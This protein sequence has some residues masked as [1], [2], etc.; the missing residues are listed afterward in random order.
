[1]VG[2]GTRV[3]DCNHKVKELLREWTPLADALETF[4]GCEIERAHTA[5]GDCRA[6][7]QLLQALVT[8]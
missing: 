7:L 6:A 4:A 1:M 8:G 3:L 5:L 2:A